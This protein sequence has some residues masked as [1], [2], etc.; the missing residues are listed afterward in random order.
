MKFSRIRFQQS[1]FY[2]QREWDISKC[3]LQEKC[4]RRNCWTSICLRWIHVF[5]SF[6]KEYLQQNSSFEADN[7]HLVGK[8]KVIHS[9]TPLFLRSTL[10]LSFQ[11]EIT[12]LS[13]RIWK[14][15]VVAQFIL[16]SQ[17]LPKWTDKS[18]GP[19]LRTVRVPA[20]IWI[21]HLPTTS[22][23]HCH[24]SQLAQLIFGTN[25]TA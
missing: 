7:A 21:G 9:L 25:Y 3:S 16:L 17:N 10:V 22:Q 6:I 11:V 23:K 8:V 18:R 19:S 12:L 4:V 15:T 14:G 24:L 2:S 1:C 5:Y 13:G 20:K